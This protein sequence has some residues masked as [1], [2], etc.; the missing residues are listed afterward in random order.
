MRA[1]PAWTSNSPSSVAHTS[2]VPTL[3]QPGSPEAPRPREKPSMKMFKL[4]KNR[5]TPPTAA[6]G[7]IRRVGNA[8]S[9]TVT[10]VS[11]A[12][13]TSIAK[14]TRSSPARLTPPMK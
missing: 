3:A 11:S 13:P 10:A 12:E 2:V 4:A 1:A 9:P 5:K 7:R 14:R 6:S 8:D